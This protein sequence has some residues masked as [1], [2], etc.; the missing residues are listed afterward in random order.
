[1]AG[2]PL[3]T[4][5]SWS[6]TTVEADTTAPT[7]V[8]RDPA[9]G[10]VGVA[11]ATTVTATF[12]E[13]MDPASINAGTVEL[14]HPTSGV[15]AAT[16]AYSGGALA[17]TLTPSQALAPSTTYQATVR[18]GAS[19][20]KDVAGNPLVA[21]S[22]WSFTTAADGCP[23][24]I[25]SASTVPTVLE[26]PDTAAVELGVKFRS[27]VDGFI[28]GL[29]FY[30]GPNNTGTHVGTLWDSGGQQ[31][32]RA[33]FVGETASGWQQVDFASPVAVV[34]NTVYVASYHTNVGRY[35]ADGNYFAGSGVDNGP[36]RALQNGESGGNGVYAYS[37]VPT[38][39]SSTYQST[40]YWVDVVF[41][42]T[43]GP[44]T[45]PPTVTS[46]TP[47]DGAT[48]VSPA[49]TATATFSEAMDG[50]TISS[51]TVQL[52]DP[53][54]NPV[55]GTVTYNSANRTATLTPAAA[56]AV[57]TL[58]QATVLGGPGG[59]KD[60]AGN[61]LATTSTWSFTT[62]S[63]ATSQV[64]FTAVASQDGWVRESTESSN[65][66]GVISATGNTTRALRIGDDGSDRQFKTIV[67]FDTSSLPDDATIISATLRLR[68]GAVTGSNP[69][70]SLGDCF[71]DVIEGGFGGN[72]A[73]A[74]GDFQAPATAV[75]VATMTNA[76][77]N[78]ALSE[79]VLNVD[80]MA[81]V[82]RTGTTQLRVYFE[83]DDDDDG[84]T[85]EM[86]FYAGENATAGNRP[87]LVISYST[88]GS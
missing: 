11:L 20:V 54:N 72:V 83:L 61:A 70:V 53:L 48:G 23:C 78:G 77:V 67:S 28:T 62:A 14:R 1:L 42:T 45:T 44:D 74:V 22:T 16:V 5:L 8:S 34:A 63:S 46:R 24:T 4:D 12:S 3:A 30:K 2:N 25:W 84:S 69:F 35:S 36:L 27:N 71:V 41:T 59:V 86:G 15:V 76:A 47:V 43:T 81:A 9:N 85:D 32:A 56:L 37:A 57:S 21:D 13:A 49:T 19:G 87:Q 88:P 80:G 18:G 66:G 40:N 39:P 6:F 58:Y 82:N 51:A 52:R 50:A 10:A 31:L 55:A 60:L 17:A 68:R 29:R 26:D 7:V 38:F 75:Q 33:T 65:V 73:L 79:G 64:T